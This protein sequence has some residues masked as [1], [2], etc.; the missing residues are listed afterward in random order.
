MAGIE[1][2]VIDRDTKLRDF[3]RDLRVGDLTFTLQP[4]LRG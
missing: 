2:V 3:R 1:L 4:G